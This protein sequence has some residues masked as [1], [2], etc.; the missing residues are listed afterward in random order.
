MSCIA[1]HIYFSP[2]CHS[3]PGWE[4]GGNPCGVP[5]MRSSV[6]RLPHSVL[7]K[8]CGLLPMHYTVHELAK[9]L[10]AVERTLRDWLANGAPHFKDAKGH[11]WVHGREFS[12]WVDGARKPKQKQKRMKDNEGFCM[13]CKKTMEMLAVSTRHIRG[14]LTM[15]RGTCSQCG[16]IIHRGGR[17]PSNPAPAQ[18]GAISRSHD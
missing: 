13:H 1:T 9:E 18:L 17:I 15:A 5:T 12:R 11:I 10:G 7:V 2:F 6:F 4:C 8:S 16:R 3:T 14:K